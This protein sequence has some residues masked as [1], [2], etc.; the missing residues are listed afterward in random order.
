MNKNRYDA[1]IVGARCAGSPTA[2]LLAR[3]GY[4]VLVVDRATFPS[5]TISTH[6]IHPPGVAALRRWGLLDRVVATGCPPIHTYAFDFGPFVLSGAPGT[7]DEPVAYGPRRTVLD[8]L[9]VG[10]ASEAGAEVREAFT[11]DE[12]IVEDGRV[13][14]IRGHAMG[15]QSV[16]EEARVVIGADGLHSLVARSV[17]PE[18]YKEKPQLQA[19]YYTYWSGL[20][21]NGGFEAYDRGDRAFAAWPT[22]DDLTLVIAGWPIAEFEA[23]KKD[24]EGN[25][26]QVLERAPAF[27]KRIRAAKRE[28]R[29]VG[30][31]VPNFFRKPF[32]SGW[33]L[34]G[35]SGYHKDFIT[36]QGI[37]DA[38]RDA[39]L[40]GTALDEAFSGARPFDVAMTAYQ[41]A[42]DQKVLPMYEFTCQFAA[43]APPPP[44]VQQLLR[45][46]HGNQ[47]AMDGFVRVFSGVMSAAEYF[48]EEN[49]GRILAASTRG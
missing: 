28:E 46:A 14:G 12:V 4:K 38:F 27:G 35:D 3:K 10:A 49:V 7:D 30:T 42:R 47:E 39:E 25:Y 6:L 34:V 36:A 32:G 16:T 5:H 22:N 21:M 31:A 20:P 15:G 48:S 9:L 29:F 26:L 37:S 40:C 17:H 19:S 41:S 44:E 18:E 2:M 13:T 11:V 8:K 23:N 24:I 43:L 1:I 33:A 45:A